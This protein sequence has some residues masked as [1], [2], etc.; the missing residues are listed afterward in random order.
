MRPPPQTCENIKLFEQ[1][2]KLFWHKNSGQAAV[3]SI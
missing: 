1:K 3:A 2:A